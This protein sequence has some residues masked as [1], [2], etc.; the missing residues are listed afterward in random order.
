VVG[1]VA[2][3]VPYGV[4]APGDLLGVSL[5]A[6]AAMTLPHVAVVAWLDGRQG[7]WRA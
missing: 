7:I 1:G 4:A 3:A 5:V 6:I 2:L